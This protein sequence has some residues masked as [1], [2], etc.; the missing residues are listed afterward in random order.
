M[1]IIL[2][3]FIILFL[4]LSV[5]VLAVNKVNINSASLEEL[6]TLTG[7]GAVKAQAIIDARPFLTVDDLERVK[8]IGTKT[9]QKIKEQGYACVDCSTTQTTAET[10]SEEIKTE[11]VKIYS[12]R[13][14]INEILP[15]PAGTD[16]TGEWVE[17]YNSNNFS[18][19]LSDWKIKDT[20]GTP[21]VYTFQKNTEILALGYLVLRRPDTKITLNNEEDGLNLSSPDNKIIDFVEYNKAIKN[22]SYNRTNSSW[23]WSTTLTQGLPNVITS[24]TSEKVLSKNKKSVNNNIEAGYIINQEKGLS[25]LS[26]SKINPWFLFLIAILLTIISA[27]VVLFIKLKFNNHVRT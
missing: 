26:E 24:K 25:A 17:L 14:L 19:D 8:G 7:I 11:E 22:Q 15:S 6:E 27:V 20:K 3:S 21:T 23:Q 16:E 10:K 9:L 1:K 18:V 2:K 4:F 5:F 13:I 12:S